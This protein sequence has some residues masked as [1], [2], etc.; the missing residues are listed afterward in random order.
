MSAIQDAGTPLRILIRALGGAGGGVLVKWIVAADD[1][2]SAT[3]RR[4]ASVNVAGGGRWEI[5]A[6]LPFHD[7][8]SAPFSM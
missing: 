5:V 8:G 6:S 4:A 2:S 3:A 7:S 1:V